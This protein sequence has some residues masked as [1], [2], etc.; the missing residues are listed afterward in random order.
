LC[1]A[2]ELT[3]DWSWCCLDELEM[4][5]AMCG[6]ALR[7]PHCAKLDKTC[8]NIGIL[9]DLRVMRCSFEALE[10]VH[11]RL[12]VWGDIPREAP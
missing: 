12:V 10:I 7:N 8:A 4:D 3:D 9:G 6:E 11:V 2:D 5:G 1:E